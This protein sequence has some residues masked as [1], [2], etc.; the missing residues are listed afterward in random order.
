MEIS[1]SKL[2]YDIPA[3][4]V[5]FLVAL[6]LCLG[7]ALASG[8]P[9]LSGILSGIIGG[10]IVGALSGSQTSVSGPAAGLVAI[11]LAAI[12][13]LGSF[14]LFTVS[15][16]IAGGF[17]LMLGFL[18][19]GVL[20]NYI[21]SNVIKGLLASI[22]I[23][24]VL[25]QIPHAFGYDNTLEVEYAFFQPNGE[26]TF[27]HLFNTYQHISIGATLV[28]LVS[29]LLL[30]FWKKLPFSKL[31]FLPS[32]LFV[33][34]FGVIINA[35]LKQYFPD[36][37]VKPVH[38][39]NIPATSFSDLFGFFQL[40]TIAAFSNSEVWI[41]AITIAI[42]ASIETLL[43][44]EA[45]DNVDPQKRE[46]PPNRELLAQ[47]IGNMISGLVGGLPITSVIVR[48]SV[49]IQ[50][51]GQTKMASIFHGVFL[52]L[53][54][55]VLSPYLNYI[56]FA[57]L[58][59][60]LIA[61]GYKLSKVS[62]YKDMY[63]KGLNQF[64]PFVITIV[65]ILFSD[66]LIGILI[67]LA[68][69]IFYLLKSNLK[70]PFVLQKSKIL[71]HETIRIELPNQVSFLNKNMIKKALMDVPHNAN[72]IV[73]ATH[74]N[75]IDEDILALLLEFKNVI[76]PERG[77]K[78]NLV[79][80][81]VGQ[82]LTDEHQFDY[83]INKDEQQHHTLYQIITYL[84][85]GNERF[86]AGHANE[87]YFSQQV[88][89]SSKGQYPLA[90]II[91][92]VD[93]RATPEIIFDSN[94]GD[95][96]SIRIA[97]NVVNREIIE[98]IKLSIKKLGCKLVVVMGHSNCGMVNIAVNNAKDEDYGKIVE[99][100]QPSIER[101]KALT[102]NEITK[103]TYEYIERYNVEKS[104]DD[105][106]TQS[107]TL[108]QRC[109]DGSIGIVGAYYDTKDGAVHFNQLN[110]NIEVLEH[111]LAIDIS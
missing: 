77:I 100:L 57:S 98:S 80:L 59:A 95:L 1:F 10:I 93:S 83:V 8:A 39:V 89:T 31:K 2:K 34:L 111:N 13:S 48:S 6:P 66:L 71:D 69:S 61:T 45:V 67:G 78:L 110:M 30:I 38:L 12:A 102:N 109:K 36:Y 55:L 37:A 63:A 106:L 73:D 54:I 7:V 16:F 53:S 22:G 68:V 56:P 72:V 47:G 25:K 75:H 107:K 85:A 20:A 27:S 92:C 87:K 105:I 108:L 86:V 17:Q 97:G 62:L 94:L 90:V 103:E 84:Q 70:N 35:I 74:S 91:S 82:E 9:L 29:L 58:A 24:L 44:I 26:N 19:G 3:S 28:S 14:Q 51:G 18:K 11:V 42:V 76:A 15:L 65:A 99:R 21:P 96:I 81:Q 60:I 40:P 32:S 101:A 43:N 33:V 41:T 23:L 52:L 50:S 88:K 104:I 64:I 49:N 79:G 4:L 5:V 46:S